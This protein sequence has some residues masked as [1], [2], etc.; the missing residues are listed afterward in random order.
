MEEKYKRKGRILT[1]VVISIRIVVLFTVIMIYSMI[2][3][4][5]VV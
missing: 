5:Y 3:R 1:G 4:M 2:L